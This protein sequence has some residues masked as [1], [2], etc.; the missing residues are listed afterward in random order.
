[1]IRPSCLML[2]GAGLLSAFAAPA[3]AAPQAARF[4]PPRL[5]TGPSAAPASAAASARPLAHSKTASWRRRQHEAAGA[6]LSRV[7]A[8]NRSAVREPSADDYL[9]A[10]QVYPWT[11]GALYRLYAAPGRVSDIA[12]QPGETLV[13]VAAGDTVRWIVGDTASGAGAARRTHILVK[14][15][16]AGLSTN[17]VIAT[18]RRVYHVDARSNADTAMASIS[19]TYPEDALL[20]LRGT[21]PPADPPSLG[22]AVDQLNFDYRIIGK[23]LPW[24]PIRAFDDGRQVFI[25]FPPTLAQGDAPPLFVTGEDGRAEL[26]NYRIRGLYYV[27]DRLFAAAELRMGEKHQQVVRIVR[28]GPDARLD[29]RA[30]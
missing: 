8:A 15:S 24:R 20:A 5:L 10:A 28:G 27:V 23:K 26:V 22:V 2:A 25:E 6:P 13:S 19:W 14:P 1:M 7:A 17:L 21:A 9:G 11:E 18:D 12:L 29:R 30:R 4:H 16:A 3:T